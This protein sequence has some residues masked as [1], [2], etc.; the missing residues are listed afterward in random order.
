ML[1]T[2]PYV[3][4]NSCWT[5]SSWPA[6]RAFR[7]ALSAPEQTQAKL[8]EEMLKG[9][10][11]SAFGKK[12]GFDRIRTIKDY[13]ARVPIRD[14]EG[15]ADW[16][17]RIQD[18]ESNVLTREPVVAFEKTSGSSSA[19]KYIPYTKR[20][21]Q[22]FQRAIGA[23]IYDLY[24]NTPG[25]KRGSSYWCITPLT[26]EHETTSAG[27]PVGLSNDAEYLGRAGK[28][29]FKQSLT[30]PPAI[31]TLG[32][33]E[34]CLYTTCRLL[35][36]S[37][38]LSFISVW[39]PSFLTVLMD[40]LEQHAAA[41]LSDLREGVCRPPGN[42]KA[43]AKHLFRSQCK[44][45]RNLGEQ[46]KADGCFDPSL[47]WPNLKVISCWADGQARIAL[48]P[49]TELFP[50][51]SIQGKGLLAT[52]GVV[53][54]PMVG[55]Q[56]HC[57]ALTSHFLEFIDAAEGF[58]MLAHELKTGQEY[59]V[60][61][62]TGGGLWRYKLN[63]RIRVIGF[64]ERTP[65]IEFMSREDGVS[66]LRGE[67]LNPLFAAKAI[68]EWQAAQQWRGTFAMLAP[69]NSAVPFYG[70]FVDGR[71]QTPR[72]AEKIEE[73][74]ARNPHYHY[75]RQ[76]GQLGRARIFCI[77][78]NA[79]AAYLQHCHSLA[80]RAGGVKTTY[81]HK[82]FGWE[83]IFAGRWHELRESPANAPDAQPLHLTG[84]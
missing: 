38:H 72:C 53:S 36:Q 12:H 20:L 59:S 19:A 45:A 54:I 27:I 64:A 47:L 39:S 70:L 62:T 79:A 74:L 22:Q 16:I 8:L 23:W 13:Q 6:H 76:L 77:E 37:P 66:D 11:S 2:L 48:R 7:R 33:L 52:E 35:L 57:L 40:Y 56:G 50:R 21:L 9:S 71:W 80:Q 69:V 67:K 30:V 73:L 42:S 78:R 26:R 28:L 5:L 32:D 1:T 15:F 58:P 51:I 46:R 10:A 24:T 3:I 17:D 84:V 41:L 14:Y 4:A 60:V 63:D 83:K 25:L 55:R 81:L 61:I 18:G 31:G 34:S 68:Q 43:M 82:A 29:F 49:V 44:R 65:L 75:C